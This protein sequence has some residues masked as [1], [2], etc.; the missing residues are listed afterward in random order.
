MAMC[1]GRSWRDRRSLGLIYTAVF[2]SL[3]GCCDELVV[4]ELSELA[5]S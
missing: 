1:G 4:F 2:V 3:V 5:R